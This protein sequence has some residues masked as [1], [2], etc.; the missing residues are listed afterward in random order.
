MYGMHF[1]LSM[2]IIGNDVHSIYSSFSGK[3][4]IKL[5][6]TLNIDLSCSYSGSWFI[7][8]IQFFGMN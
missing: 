6:K 3:H 2:V 4:E 5:N 1:Q 7:K 8:N